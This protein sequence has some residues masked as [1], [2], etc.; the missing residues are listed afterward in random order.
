MKSHDH[1]PL[2]SE[3]F[4]D[5]CIGS[6]A[7]YIFLYMPILFYPVVQSYVRAYSRCGVANKAYI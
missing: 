6:L 2:I 4:I 1:L 5:P 7:R 3:M